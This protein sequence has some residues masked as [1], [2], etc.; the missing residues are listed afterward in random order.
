M[1]ARWSSWT[2][3]GTSI[4]TITE[5]RLG[6]QDGISKLQINVRKFYK[7]SCERVLFWLHQ[8]AQ[9]AKQTAAAD[10]QA[11]TVQENCPS[12][13]QGGRGGRPSRSSIR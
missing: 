1:R 12:Q 13:R 3:T 5:N 7:V 6:C 2:A 11:D 4:Y 9:V 8:T 10:H